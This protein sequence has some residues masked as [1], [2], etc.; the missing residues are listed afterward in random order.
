MSAWIIEAT[1]S[2]PLDEAEVRRLA[3]ALRGEDI[4][5]VV[6][7]FLHAYVNPGHEE[8]AA[9]IFRDVGA[10]WEVVTS[11]SV[12]R[13]YYEFERTSTA[14][15]QGYLQPLV[16]RYA[17]GLERRLGERR[18]S[19]PAFVMQSNGGLAPL[20]HLARSAARIVR[21]GPAAGVMAAARLAGRAGFENVITGDMGGT[22]YDVAVVMG[23]APRVAEMTELDF[24]IPLRLP[25]IDVHTIG[26]GGG[27]IAFLDRG[28]ILQVGPRSAGALPGPVCFGRGGTEPTVTDANAVLARINPAHPIGMK[29]LA[30]L[31][32][33]GA[34]SAMD[35][36]G[37]SIGLS[38]EATAE[39]ILTIIN[40]RM[41]GRTRLLSV[42]QGHDP[43]DFALVMFGGAGPLHGA[44]IMRE[45]GVRTMLIPP[46]PGVLC[47]LGCAIADV[48]HDL[49]RTIERPVAGLDIGW[50]HEVLGAQRQEGLARLGESGVA[51]ERVEVAHAA[52]M[53]YQGQI[54]ALRVPIEAGL[55]SG[56]D[57]RGL[58]GR[59]P[60]RVRQHAR[61]HSDD[62]GRPEIDRARRARRRPG[63]ATG[64]PL[65]AARCADVKATRLFRQLAGHGDLWPR[66]AFP[67]CGRRWPRDHRA[68]RHH[69][70]DRARHARARRRTL[71]HSRRDPLMDITAPVDPVTLAVVR[72][73]L[74]QIADEMDLHLIH[75]AI[76]PIISETNDCAHGLFKPETGETIAQGGYGLPQFLANMQFSVQTVIAAAREAGGFKPGDVW[77][78]ND[79]Y[80]SGT[81]LN[82]VVLVAPYF[83]GDRLFALFA[84]TGH[85]MDMG[86][87]VPGGWAPRATEIHQEGIIIPPLRLYD[88]GAYNAPLVRMITAN[89]RL[90]RQIEGDLAAM[91]NVF[92][93]GRRGLDAL[94]AKYGAATLSACIDEMMQR[95]EAQMRSYIA[96][97][98]DGTYRITDYFDN[99]GVEDTRLTVAFALT[100][101]GSDLFC[102]FT[103]TSPAAKGPMNIA[104]STTKS[105]CFVAL[106]HIFPDV[107]VNGG[108][109]R[110]IRFTIPKGCILAAA[111]P[112]PVGGTT[113]VIQRVIDVMFGA[114][115]QAIPAL[116]PAAPFGTTGVATVSGHHPETGIYYVAVYPYP[117]GYGASAGS[118]GLINGTPPGSMAKFMSIEASEHRYPLRFEYYA[119]REG[120]GGAGRHRGGCGTT[121][122]MTA[123][124]D[125]LVSIL[126]DRVDHPPF[127]VHGGASAA[128]NHVHLVTG[129]REWI[130]PFRSKLE[131]QPL[132]AGD[133]LHLASPG[134]GGF[135]R[136]L[137][138]SADE[139]EQ[140]LNQGLVDRVAAELVYGVV[141]EH[142]RILAGRPSY[143]LDRD[144][145]ARRRQALRHS[146]LSD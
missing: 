70:R 97:I 72:G 51:F 87:S 120:S 86:G 2:C 82:D 100:V 28:G 41:A 64:G 96:E 30:R 140:D 129:G 141:V 59:L 75:A 65:A 81:H 8:R 124:A 23:G 62:A 45:V 74:E 111:Y 109:F 18:F 99:D 26:A 77:I 49:S 130:P 113:D 138:R 80:T 128:P 15:V 12:S 118:D 22:S 5:A 54:H 33:A 143:R 92:T 50:V 102:D 94:I 134:G 145:T 133:S 43:R 126:G 98:P 139:V 21:S 39:A 90:P 93:V 46:H 84:N 107:P 47:A 29:H 108:A 91:V 115:A 11:S 36:L 52:D 7:A 6:I 73:A 89:S 3:E 88:A 53:S 79:P 127:G 116:T 58:R 31:D 117:G 61:G 4:E 112:S 56:G 78:L 57:G 13:E 69:Q 35:R 76:S 114:L 9:A 71:Q 103:G 68:G 135:D 24:R 16:A 105:L 60:A 121:Y 38:I 67:G 10:S 83:I 25:M 131:K 95:S 27:S 17:K 34:R 20:S 66:T 19:A 48:R 55:G 146:G 1:S 119:I 42:E 123:L 44:A 37:R 63:G 136:A 104:D 144:A 122:G 142:T 14:V 40:Q 106:K 137:A 101:T 132:R 32:V 125:C 85:W 110:P